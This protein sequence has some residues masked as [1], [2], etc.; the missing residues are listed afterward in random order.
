MIAT[1][2]LEQNWPRRRS[3]PWRSRLKW[4]HSPTVRCWN[5]FRRLELNFCW[6]GNRWRGKWPC[7]EY[8]EGPRNRLNRQRI[9]TD[10]RGQWRAT[11]KTNNSATNCRLYRD[12]GAVVGRVVRPGIGPA[13]VQDVA[14]QVVSNN[15]S[16]KADWAS[17]KWLSIANSTR[18]VN[19]TTGSL[20]A[21][22]LASV[23]PVSWK[24][25]RNR[26]TGYQL[27]EERKSLTS[28]FYPHAEPWNQNVVIWVLPK[29]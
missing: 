14:V 13:V 26:R 2:R 5:R 22:A 15:R 10:R 17:R 19:S 25:S 8:P 24:P 7:T 6:R 23:V 20:A 16:I 4:I 1:G 28:P 3:Q 29:G 21:V 12:I 9:S 27:A 11:R 18:S